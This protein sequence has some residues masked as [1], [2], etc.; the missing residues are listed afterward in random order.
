MQ[1]ININKEKLEN[2][3]NSYNKLSK[4]IDAAI[5]ASREKD[6]KL[7]IPQRFNKPTLLS[8]KLADFLNKPHGTE[9]SRI[10][11]TELV[12]QYIWDNNIEIS[13]ENKEIKCDDKLSNLLNV[14]EELDIVTVFNIRR[15]LKHNYP[16]DYL[17]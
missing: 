1:T 13:S 15:Y 11:V 14:D 17:K 5:K 10:D 6:K 8:E 3:T 7:R 9:M 2:F 12:M 16:D 4:D